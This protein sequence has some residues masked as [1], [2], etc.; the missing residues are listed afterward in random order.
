MEKGDTR[1]R[2]VQKEMKRG[3]KRQYLYEKYGRR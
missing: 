3:E 1:S 2:S